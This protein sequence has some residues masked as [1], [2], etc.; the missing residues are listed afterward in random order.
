MLILAKIAF[1]FGRKIQMW[2]KPVQK[3]PLLKKSSF[4]TSSHPFYDFKSNFDLN[5]WRQF[6]PKVAKFS[7][8]ENVPRFKGKKEMSKNAKNYA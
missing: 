8:R 5:N 4:H 2:M 1:N 7:L 6:S 3:I